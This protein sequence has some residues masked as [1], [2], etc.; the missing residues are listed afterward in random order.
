MLLL[1]HP[2]I[3][4][5]CEPPAG[6]AKLAGALAKHHYPCTLLDANLEGLLHL[7]TA[8]RQGSDTWSK[9]AC[10]NVE[11]D[12]KDLRNISLYAN[13]DRYKR[14]V[15]DIG[16]VLALA[17][18]DCGSTMTLANYEDDCLSPMSSGDLL[19]AAEHPQ[20]NPFFPWFSKRLS[21]LVEKINPSLIGFSLNYLSQALTTFAMIGFLK[22]RFPQLP[23]VVGGG[24]ATSWMRQAEW[25]NPFT[26]L[27]D[28]LIDGPGEEGLFSLLGI[29]TEVGHAPPDYGQLADNPYLAPGFVLPYAASSGCWWNRCSFCPE[30]A[31]GGT[32]SAITPHQVMADLD[33]L[34]AKT[35]PSLL[36]LVDNAIAPALLDSLISRPEPVPWYGF[37]RVTEHLA[38]QDFCDTLRRSGCVML[39]LGIESGDRRVLE[40][41]AKGVDP[42]LASR[43]L[44]ALHAA[45]IATYVYLLFGTP[46]ETLPEARKTLEFTRLHAATITFLNLAIFNLPAINAPSSGLATRP[47]YD[48][49]LSLYRDFVHPRGWNR[50]DVRLFLEKEFKRDPAVRPIVLRD[51]PL[52]TSN[53]A[54]FL[55]MACHFSRT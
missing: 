23:L 52:F 25:R 21:A 27:L 28:H 45:G 53:H 37:A 6:I 39:K 12:L 55:Q 7:L 22:N 8:P 47:F 35:T 2:P 10:R 18:R 36:H 16:R 19:Q 29:K 51:P 43:A 46:S 31:E 30:K 17:G 3:A 44:K 38:D 24:L 42:D 1:I 20:K 14:A 49:D 26:G 32:Y 34:T 9:R 40:E 41:M 50:K 4:K 13:V 33:L 48:G 15:L 54:P 5:P 11:S